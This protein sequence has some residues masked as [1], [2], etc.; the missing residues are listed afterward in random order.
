MRSSEHLSH[1]LSDI[2]NNNTAMTGTDVATYARERPERVRTRGRHRLPHVFYLCARSGRHLGRVPVARPRPQGA[3][4]DRLL[5]A[6]PRRV[7]QALSDVA[8][9][10]S[11]LPPRPWRARPGTRSQRISSRPFPGGQHTPPGFA[12]VPSPSTSCGCQ[13]IWRSETSLGR[14]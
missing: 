4:R 3:Q 1:L 12:R 10:V 9:K 7:R 5:A 2:K 14:G 13:T 8:V 11:R 6:P